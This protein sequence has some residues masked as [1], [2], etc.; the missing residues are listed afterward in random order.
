MKKL[1]SIIISFAISLAASGQDRPKS[2]QNYCSQSHDYPINY[3]EQSKV[4][5]GYEY[6]YYQKTFRKATIQRNCG[7]GGTVLGL[8][9]L[10]GS[11]IIAPMGYSSYTNDAN[12]TASNVLGY[13]GLICVFVG[14]PI[15]IS[16]GVKR[17]NNKKAM[18]LMEGKIG[19][20][21]GTTGN[22]MGLIFKF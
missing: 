3:K 2:N 20:S 13:S 22:G 21:L 5:H 1:I 14:I 18:E 12:A 9:L 16:G 4:Y 6:E 15:W 7:I 11:F 10:A 8:G 19:L 17:K